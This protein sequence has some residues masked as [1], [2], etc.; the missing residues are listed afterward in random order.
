MGGKVQSQ[1]C[2]VQSA[3]CRMQNAKWKD[4][5]RSSLCPTYSALCTLHLLPRVG[6]SDLGDFHD[7]QVIGPGKIDPVNYRLTAA[8]LADGAGGA[9]QFIGGPFS[10]HRQQLPLL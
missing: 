10:L 1:E 3:E 2:R 5:M 8:G 4:A 9:G 6:F 7:H